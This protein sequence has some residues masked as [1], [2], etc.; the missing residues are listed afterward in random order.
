MTRKRYIKLK[1]AEG[2][3][4][5]EAALNAKEIVAEGCSYQADYDAD[6][7]DAAYAQLYPNEAAFR[8][9][10]E[11]LCATILPEMTRAISRIAR[12]LNNAIE[13]FTAA[14]REEA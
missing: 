2:L 7:Y 13:A 4:R 12:A 9:A 10:V 6:L 1:M 14:M 5:N 11:T 3:S 8:E